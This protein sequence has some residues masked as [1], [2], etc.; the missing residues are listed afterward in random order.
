MS[1]SF[2]SLYDSSILAENASHWSSPTTSLIFSFISSISSILPSLSYEHATKRSNIA[3]SSLFLSLS[4]SLSRSDFANIKSAL[5]CS[6]VNF[7]G[8]SLVDCLSSSLSSTLSSLS[9]LTPLASLFNFLSSLFENS[10]CNLELLAAFFNKSFS[11]PVRSSGSLS[12]SERISSTELCLP[13]PKILPNPSILPSPPKKPPIPLPTCFMKSV[14][15]TPLQEYE[16]QAVHIIVANTNDSLIDFSLSID[17][18]ICSFKLIVL[19]L[20]IYSLYF[21]SFISYVYDK[22]YYISIK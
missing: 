16:I 15:N 6:F 21:L 19:V 11:L 12:R 13:L 3:S 4:S 5:K 20:F 2:T 22:C 14:S 17:A 1:E 7:S 18:C 9:S 8:V 10:F